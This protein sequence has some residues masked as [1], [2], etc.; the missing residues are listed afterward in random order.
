MDRVVLLRIGNEKCV[1]LQQAETYFDFVTSMSDPIFA[2]VKDM[3]WSSKTI[4]SSCL[5]T[6]SGDGQS[7]SSS[8]IT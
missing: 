3:C 2:V 4:S 5:P 6:L 7:L 8:F 1:S